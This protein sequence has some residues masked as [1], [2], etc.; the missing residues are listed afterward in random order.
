MK[1]IIHPLCVS[2]GADEAGAAGGGETDDMVLR[3][4][5]MDV[6]RP[7]L[8]GKNIIICLPTGSGKTRVAVYVAK[9]HLDSRNAEGR[10]GKVVVLV[11]K[12]LKATGL[13]SS[14][15]LLPPSEPENV[16]GFF[17]FARRGAVAS[18]R[19][20]S[21]PVAAFTAGRRRRLHLICVERETD[22]R[23]APERSEYSSVA[24]LQTCNLT[25]FHQPHPDHSNPQSIGGAAGTFGFLGLCSVINPCCVLFLADS[26]CG[27]ALR[28]R[29]PAIFEGCV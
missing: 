2:D 4:Y 25:R 6:A 17:A 27:A 21:L 5:Q 13:H 1:A 19:A 8:E 29:V 15:N 24:G 10:K 26:S 22:G 28:H 12:V 3:D 9:K 7:A 20:V 23:S 16:L 14:L 11:N 18:A